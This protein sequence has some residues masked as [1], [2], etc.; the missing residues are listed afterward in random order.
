MHFLRTNA[1]LIAA[2][3]D[4]AANVRL[5]A[6]QSLG[7]LGQTSP[8]VT[9][10]LREG[11]RKAQSGSIRRDSA[12]FLGQVGLADAATINALWHGL[13]D[14]YDDV[15]MACAQALAQL[16]RRFPAI[17]P[18]LEARF[19]EAIQDPKFD[20]PDNTSRPAYDYAY[21]GLWLLVVGGEVEEA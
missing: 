18:S 13:L 10:G 7:L 21:D 1:A 2:L 16:G 4:A 19:I 9:A 12:R 20:K 11:L 14:N 3:H 15:R 6:A 8:E 17:T 5:Y